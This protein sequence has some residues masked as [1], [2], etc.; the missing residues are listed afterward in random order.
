MLFKAKE[1]PS[2]TRWYPGKIKVK[3]DEDGTYDI[4]YDDGDF[5][6]HVRQECVRCSSDAPAAAG[7]AAAGAGGQED[8]DDREEA[9]Y[10]LREPS[11]ADEAEAWVG[12]FE[13]VKRSAATLAERARRAR[14]R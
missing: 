9:V 3:H 1:N 5:E 6:R 11:I 13:G 14:R 7:E 12:W 8:H 10:L 4:K 2:R